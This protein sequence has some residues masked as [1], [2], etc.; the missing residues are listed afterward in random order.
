MYTLRSK[1]II[2]LGARF[3]SAARISPA[4]AMSTLRTLGAPSQVTFQGIISYR[5]PS[6]TISQIRSAA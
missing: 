2:F 5:E 1:R 4:L 3:W 6:L